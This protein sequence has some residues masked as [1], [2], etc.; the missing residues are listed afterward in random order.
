MHRRAGVSDLSVALVCRAFD[1]AYVEAGQV[2]GHTT[3]LL[4]TL[5]GSRLVGHQ[6]YLGR[7]VD[8]GH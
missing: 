3:E 7:V 5:P 2:H 4:Q 8:S 6:K 1:S